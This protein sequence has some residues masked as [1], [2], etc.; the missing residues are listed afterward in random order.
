[1]ETTLNIGMKSFCEMTAHETYCKML[2]LSGLPDEELYRRMGRVG[3][4]FVSTSKP[5]NAYLET[6]NMG[7]VEGKSAT[8]FRHETIDLLSPVLYF[9]LSLDDLEGGKSLF[10]SLEEHFDRLICETANNSPLYG[11]KQE[12]IRLGNK[13]VEAISG[14]FPGIDRSIV[15]IFVVFRMKDLFNVCTRYS[16]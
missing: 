3:R 6:P 5:K 14:K 11:Y 2:E 12:A 16:C 7:D 15:E 1:M 10:R 9:D 8:F 13:C 4:Q